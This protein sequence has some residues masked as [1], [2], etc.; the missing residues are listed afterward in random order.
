MPEIL[1]DSG[2]FRHTEFPE[3]LRLAYNRTNE[4]AA[5]ASGAAKDINLSTIASILIQE[6][7]RW[8]DR[9]ASDFL[10]T[11]DS[12]RQVIHESTPDKDPAE[13]LFVFAVR[14]DGVDHTAFFMSRIK[15]NI[16]P[17]RPAY[18]DTSMYR[19]VYALYIYTNHGRVEC[20]LKNLTY[21]F[22]TIDKSDLD[23]K[24]ATGHD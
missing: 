8:T 17:F 23:R 1:K 20:Q 14:Q 12:V 13:A 15:R 21:A 2:L 5:D 22:T 10:I 24:D 9:Y 11:W 19:R 6:C 18:A 7:G 16:E 3:T 4:I